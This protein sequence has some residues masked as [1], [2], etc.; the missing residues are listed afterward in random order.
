MPQ[1]TPEIMTILSAGVAPH[2]TVWIQ[3]GR[4]STEIEIVRM[5]PDARYLVGVLHH[6]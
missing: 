5:R 2:N 4:V 3:M 1:H 6:S